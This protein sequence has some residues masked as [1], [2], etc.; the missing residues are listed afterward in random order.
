MMRGLL[1]QNEH[2]FSI[3]DKLALK[4]GSVP[5]VLGKKSSK[6]LALYEPITT[7]LI[8]ELLQKDTVFADIGANIGYYTRLASKIIGDNGMIYSFEPSPELCRHIEKIVKGRKNAK[9]FKVALGDRNYT[10][11]LNMNSKNSGGNSLVDTANANKRIAVSVRRLDSLIKKVEVAKID[12]EGFENQVLKGFGKLLD[13]PNLKLIVEYNHHIMFRTT[14]DY[15]GTIDLLNKKGFKV[16]E[17]LPAGL[18]NE[19]IKSYKQL[20][21]TFVNLYAYK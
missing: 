12:V 3:Y 10:D 6:E 5:S 9:L 17:I 15:N 1:L 20:H 21:N 11:Y 2:I 7:A 18:G 8:T 4:Y 16:V 14:K 13:N 19:Q